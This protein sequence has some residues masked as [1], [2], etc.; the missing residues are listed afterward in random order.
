M[1]LLANFITFSNSSSY[2]LLRLT[3]FKTTTYR[4]VYIWLNLKEKKSFTIYGE[5]RCMKRTIG[6]WQNDFNNASFFISYHSTLFIT[7]LASSGLPITWIANSSTQTQW[8][9]LRML[10]RQKFI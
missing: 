5:M 6:M 2:F 9:I 4:Q 1:D 7:D 8:H 3:W 10:L